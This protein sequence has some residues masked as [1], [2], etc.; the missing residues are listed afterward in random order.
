MDDIFPEIDAL[1]L[2]T[3]HKNEWR[4][5]IVTR[6]RDVRARIIGYSKQPAQ[7]TFAVMK[8]ELEHLRDS[9]NNQGKV[10]QNQE[11]ALLAI[12]AYKSLAAYCALIEA[13]RPR[14]TFKPLPTESRRP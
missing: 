3:H 12:E 10:D 6:L 13:S 9:L 5:L 8:T 7:L 14:T 11:F 4:N 1:S 2:I